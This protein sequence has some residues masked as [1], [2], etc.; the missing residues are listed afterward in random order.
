MRD[1]VQLIGISSSLFVVVADV[2]VT[3]RVVL[4]NTVVES[5]A[6]TMNLPVSNVSPGE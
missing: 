2:V 4:G 5:P 6:V 1:R 3:A